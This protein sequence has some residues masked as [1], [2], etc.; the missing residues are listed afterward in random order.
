MKLF[1]KFC[2][3]HGYVTVRSAIHTCESNY[4]CAGFTYHGA[5]WDLD[6]TYDIYFFRYVL[7]NL[8]PKSEG[9]KLWVSF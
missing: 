7:T 2:S 1:P 6:F 5:I 4:E 8:I 3:I 9:P